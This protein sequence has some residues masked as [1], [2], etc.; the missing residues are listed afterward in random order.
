MEK[1]CKGI[2]HKVVKGDTLY[3]ISKLYG[4]RLVDIMKENPYV[5]VYNLPIGVELCIPT[6]V[7]EEEERRYYTAKTGETIGSVIKAIG[8]DANGLFEYNKEL[9][10]IA[11]PFGTIVRIPPDK[12]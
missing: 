12:R 2:I 1:S 11:V 7:Y 3:K 6:E 5:N 10:D 4:V 9:F 8:T